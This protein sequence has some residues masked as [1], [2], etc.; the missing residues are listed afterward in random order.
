MSCCSYLSRIILSLVLVFLV[1]TILSTSLS[2]AFPP[3]SKFSMC[4]F[5]I[6]GSC[7]VAFRKIEKT[8]DFLWLSQT[9]SLNMH[10]TQK[11]KSAYLF[12][13]EGEISKV[14]V[15]YAMLEKTVPSCMQSTIFI[16]N[17]VHFLFTVEHTPFPQWVHIPCQ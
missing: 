12:P 17:R 15:T 7:H 6:F 10:T 16:P 3:R 13:S 4:R 9:S 1:F 5:L 11:K 2:V 8:L 14:S